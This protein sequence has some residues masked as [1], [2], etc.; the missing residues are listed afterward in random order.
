MPIIRSSLI[1]AVRQYALDHYN[2]D[3]WDYLV[4]CWEDSDIA[5]AIAGATTLEQA[6]AKCHR[7]VSLLDERRREVTN[8]IF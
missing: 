6:I 2:Q 1:P 5:D 3:G 7:G 4:E 8:E